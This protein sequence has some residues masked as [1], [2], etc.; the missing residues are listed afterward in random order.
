MKKFLMMILVGAGLSMAAQAKDAKCKIT[1]NNQ[2][3]VNNTCSFSP[4]DGDGSFI[5]SG[6][7]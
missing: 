4:I 5:L 3:V 6:K 1:L 7:L 2:V